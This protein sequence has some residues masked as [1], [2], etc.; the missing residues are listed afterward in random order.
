MLNV[1]DIAK[2]KQIIKRASYFGNS[3]FGEI[4][5]I[6]RALGADDAPLLDP[7]PELFACLSLFDLFRLK[8]SRL[9]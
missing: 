3:V 2:R 6:A 9:P 5:G 7:L 4:L 8:L 1:K